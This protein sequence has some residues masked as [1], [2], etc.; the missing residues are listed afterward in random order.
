LGQLNWK[1]DNLAPNSRKPAELKQHMQAA[2]QFIG[3]VLRKQSGAAISAEE[4]DR[5]YSK[6]F[7]KPGDDAKTIQNKKVAMNN[8][9]QSLIDEAGP[10]WS[11][12]AKGGDVDTLRQQFEQS[13]GASKTSLKVPAGT[14][15]PLVNKLAATYPPGS[16]GGQCG[17]FVRNVA[18]NLGFTYPPLGDS[19]TSKVNAVQKHGS[20]R[21]TIGSVI[22]TK[23][24]PTYGHV[25]YII[26]ANEQGY[27]VAESNFKQSGKVSYGRV[28]PFNSSKIVGV[29]NPTKT[30]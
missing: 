9:L 21:A 3:A 28:I 7:P 30:A 13:G 10:A 4:F 15:V 27:V 14:S 24:N 6:Y 22:V 12:G 8:A 26:G 18:R 5:E 2:E 16:T 11:S 17:I 19:L 20:N 29:I 23:E 25:A 1:I